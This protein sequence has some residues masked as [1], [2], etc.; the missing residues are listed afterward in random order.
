[1]EALV[2]Q[3]LQADSSNENCIT[4]KYKNMFQLDL[5]WYSNILNKAISILGMMKLQTEKCLQY[6]SLLMTTSKKYSKERIFQYRQ[7]F[8]L[9]SQLINIQQNNEH[10]K[11]IPLDD[12]AIYKHSPLVL[13][14]ASNELPK[15]VKNG[16]SKVIAFN[17]NRTGY[18]KIASLVEMPQESDIPQYSKTRPENPLDVTTNPQSKVG[19]N[20]STMKKKK[21]SNKVEQEM[22]TPSPG[23]AEQK[24]KSKHQEQ[25]SVLRQITMNEVMQ[26][27][28][29]ERA[30][31]VINGIVY[32][33]TK[34]LYNHPGG[35]NNIF[36]SVGKEGTLVFRKINHLFQTIRR[37]TFLCKGFKSIPLKV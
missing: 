22:I 10:K 34:F 33:F 7:I 24:H 37:R 35:F 25:S 31:S 8:S 15:E 13:V 3:N 29:K 19:N 9:P 16:T 17:I 12:I 28:T 5:K 23:Q 26:N 14:F 30:W 21:K 32:D 11:N 1:M 27:N 18:S 2:Q 6:C 20:E 36:K 4:L